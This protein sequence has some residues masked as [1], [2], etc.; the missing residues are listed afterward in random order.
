MYAYQLGGVYVYQLAAA[1]EA[2]S[3]LLFITRNSIVDS[4]LFG[5][6]LFWRGWLEPTC[7][8]CKSVDFTGG[9]EWI[10]RLRSSKSASSISN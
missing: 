2:H 5:S 1:G 7:I 10:L 4:D 8:G 6:D 3:P 9:A